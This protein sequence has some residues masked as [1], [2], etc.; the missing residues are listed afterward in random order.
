[1]DTKVEAKAT[2]RIIDVG[3]IAG[4]KH[5]AF[6]KARRHPL[7]DIIEVAMDDVVAALLR[8]EPLEAPFDRLAVKQFGFRLVEPGG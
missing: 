7:M 8:N 2:Q 4:K 1:V 3:G 5:P 6:T